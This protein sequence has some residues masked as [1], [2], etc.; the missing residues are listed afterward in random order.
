MTAMSK[1]KVVLQ[2]GYMAYS[3]LRLTNCKSREVDAQ[4]Q[5]RSEG[6]MFLQFE[7]WSKSGEL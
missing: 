2:D 5:R 4:S 6:G 7:R 3:S 1:Q